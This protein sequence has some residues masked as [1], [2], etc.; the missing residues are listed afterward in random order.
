MAT[1]G[2]DLPFSLKMGNDGPPQQRSA[3]AAY[4]SADLLVPINAIPENDGADILSS[5]LAFP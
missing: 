2:G 3:V 1:F 4:L 5:A